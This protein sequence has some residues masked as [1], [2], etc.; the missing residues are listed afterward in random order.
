MFFFGFGCVFFSVLGFYW[1]NVSVVKCVCLWLNGSVV[2]SVC[3][4]L[5][6]SGGLQVI[7][8]F[9]F[10]RH[11]VCMRRVTK[12]GNVWICG[13]CNSVLGEVDLQLA[14]MLDV[15]C[16]E[17]ELV[18]IY[19]PIVFSVGLCVASVNSMCLLFRGQ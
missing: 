16:S 2:K 8:L 19:G 10:Q 14:Y 18:F 13:P 9:R 6:L 7:F 3:G 5:H 4:G 1:L 15:I 12:V 17:G 11:N